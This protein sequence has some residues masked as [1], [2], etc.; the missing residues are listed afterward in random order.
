[1]TRGEIYRL[2]SPRKARGHEQ[3]GARF[4][5]IVQADE[6]L[7]FNTVLIAPTST[8]A[9]AASFRPAITIGGIGTRVLAEKIRAVDLGR[10]GRLAGR[11]DAP[12]LR[13][14]DEALSLVLGL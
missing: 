6:L 5:V 9:L 10:L 4:G 13:A 14:L 8:K 11:L 12:E 3:S 7:P 2:A 1:M